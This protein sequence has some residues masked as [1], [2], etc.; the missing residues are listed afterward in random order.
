MRAGAEVRVNIGDEKASKLRK[1]INMCNDQRQ[2][3]AVRIVTAVP[4]V[5]HC[6]RPGL[7]AGQVQTPL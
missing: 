5:L 6:C 3:P 1:R 4:R 7:F 2:Q